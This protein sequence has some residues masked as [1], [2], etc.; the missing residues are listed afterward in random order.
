MV[1]TKGDKKSI[2]KISPFQEHGHVPRKAYTEPKALLSR[3]NFLLPWNKHPS[4]HFLPGKGTKCVNNLQNWKM[5]KLENRE[6][7]G[8]PS[9][10]C[11]D[12]EYNQA[13]DQLI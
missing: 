9:R 12:S 2:Q 13:I 4:E 10:S 5:K 7:Q 8:Q 1:G 11:P 3:D 6:I